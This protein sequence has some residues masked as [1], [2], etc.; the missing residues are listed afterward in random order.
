MMVSLLA[1]TLIFI[2]G[3]AQTQKTSGKA[4]FEERTKLEI[5]LEGENAQFASMLPRERKVEMQLTFSP[6]ASMYELNTEKQEE[7]TI[8]QEVEGAAVMVKMIQPD[9]KVYVDLVKGTAT[10]QRDFMSRLFLIESPV[11]AGSWKLTGNQQTILGYPCQEA[12]RERDSTKITAWFTPAI[13]VSAG[14]AMQNGLPGL[15]L[16]VDI[17]NGRRTL[18]ATSVELGL[19]DETVIRKPKEGKKVTREAFNRIVEEKRKEMQEQY[20]GSG[21]VVVRIQ[22]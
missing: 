1:G 2:T 16:L 21:G 20:G 17:D 12:V 22:Q 11:E 14:P 7:E 3:N 13:P 9:D 15:I 8:A 5:N 4:I 18:A 6:E 10:E 19:V